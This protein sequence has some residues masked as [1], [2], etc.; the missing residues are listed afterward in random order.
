MFKPA[1]YDFKNILKSDLLLVAGKY[2]LL[3]HAQLI[4]QSLIDYI[5]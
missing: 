4:N 2:L 5:P 1:I 3:K